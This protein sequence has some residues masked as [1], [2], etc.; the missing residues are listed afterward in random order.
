MRT[1]EAIDEVEEGEFVTVIWDADLNLSFFEIDNRLADRIAPSH[2]T[3]ATWVH[4]YF[5]LDTDLA[6]NIR[7]ERD[8]SAARGAAGVAALPEAS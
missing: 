6:R 3:W 1:W 8:E 2:P 4:T 7:A 5:D